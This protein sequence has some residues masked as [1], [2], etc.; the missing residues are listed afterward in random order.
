MGGESKGAGPEEARPG[1]EGKSKG[2]SIFG[3]YAHT[4]QTVLVIVV[5][6]GYPWAMMYVNSPPA[7]EELETLRGVVVKAGIGHPHLQLQTDSGVQDL[8]FPGDLQFIYFGQWPE[9][10]H[11]RRLE[12]DRLMG[13][14]AQ[15]QVDRLRY[16][17]IPSNPRIWNV[18]CRSLI[19]RYDEIRRYYERE[20]TL[21]A[22]EYFLLL[23]MGVMVFA[24]VMRDRKGGALPVRLGRKKVR[25]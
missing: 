11:H 24:A 20:A 15:V 17:F 1:L 25:S 23:T 14:E 9:F 5:M 8:D 12:L 19:I 3:R 16:V 7:K 6:C 2:R 21:Q 13:C 4:L 22:E 18:E 10:L